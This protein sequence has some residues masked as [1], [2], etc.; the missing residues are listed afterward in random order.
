LRFDQLELVV[1]AVI[2]LAAPFAGVVL[3]K[4]NGYFCPKLIA[5]KEAA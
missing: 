3:H 2:C 1:V 5:R 4:P